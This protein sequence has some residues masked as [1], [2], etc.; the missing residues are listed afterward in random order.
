MKK[1]GSDALWKVSGGLAGLIALL[2]MII[3]VNVIIGNLRVRKDLTGEK[4]YTLTS[5]TQNILKKLDSDVTLKLFFSS[6]APEVPMFLNNF[7]KKVEDLLQEYRMLGKGKV[8]LEKY[9]PKPD[10][11][12]E[13]WAQRYG[14]QGQQTG[15]FGP[16]LYF[17]LV[18]TC[19]KTEAVIPN[20]DPRAEEM[21]EYNITR[22]IYRTVHPE[23][24]VIGVISSLPVTGSNPQFSFGQQPRAPAWIVFQQLKDDYMVTQIPPMAEGIDSGISALVIVHPKDLSDKMLYAI[25]QFLLRGGRVLA[26]VDPLCVAEL[27]SS[28]PQQ[29]F[30]R[31][32]TSSNLEKLF[33]AWGIT[34]TQDKI[35]ADMG[36]ASRIRSQNNQIEDSPVWLTL[37][38]KNLS[39]KD[40]VT[41]Q[42]NTM[43]LPFAG[44]FSVNSS[45]NLTLT[46]LIT[47]SDAA[48]LVDGMMAQM[49]GAASINRNFKKEPIP[50]N[51]AV[52][53]TGKFKTAFPNGKP[54]DESE[55]KDEKKA[56]KPAE[57]EVASSSLKEGT[58]TVILVGD[59]D[60]L[61]DRFCI[62][63]GDFFGFKTMQP[64]NDNISFFANAVEQISGSSDMIGIR[65]R[66]RF[67]R[68]FDRVLALEQ[69]ARLEWQSKEEGLTEKL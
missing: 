5:G 20:L 64:I 28:P 49:M 60:M 18:A 7:A 14:L 68:P 25:D 22:L 21:L 35:L 65:S 1:N 26:F 52:R 44:S 50:L 56:D 34:F 61:Y 67:Q 4:L 16:P 31:P 12:A 27:E 41:T 38:D 8:T 24:P 63:Q 57:K 6:S 66:G 32:S 36:A 15:M 47:S 51:L 9:D 37:R 54:K 43:M 23:K 17:G 58:S 33:S 48:G 55:T 19:G 29:Q 39:R 62:E 46:P 42:L 69:K 3:A 2:V 53:L 59:V 40:I 45:S 13:E 11:D 30:G 10:S